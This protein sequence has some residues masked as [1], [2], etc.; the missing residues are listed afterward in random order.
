MTVAE[1]SPGVICRFSKTFRH[2]YVN[3]ALTKTTGFPAASFINKTPHQAGL[4]IDFANFWTDNI[5]T[6][7]TKAQPHSAEFSFPTPEGEKFFQTLLVP[8]FGASGDVI[9]VLSMTRD[10][11][12]M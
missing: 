8:E 6:V 12:E 3:P 4:S 2:I 5:K 11:T 1:K 7:F 9:T 10:I